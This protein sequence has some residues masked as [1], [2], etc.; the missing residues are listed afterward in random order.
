MGLHIVSGDWHGSLG[1][2]RKVI[3]AAH[4][5]GVNHIIQTG[6]FGWWPHYE[7]SYPGQVNDFAQ[8]RGVTVDWLD[9]NHENFDDLDQRDHDLDPQG[10]RHYER[11][12]S[13]TGRRL[14][15]LGYMP[16][17]TVFDLDGRR[18]MAFGGASSIDK[19]SRR[20]HLEWW[21]Q[22]NI[23]QG[24]VYNA[25][26]AGP[27]DYL[28]THEAPQL[29]PGLPGDWKND[30]ISNT[31]RHAIAL[32]AS[33]LAP[34]VLFHGHYH[35]PYNRQY[36]RQTMVYGLGADRNLNGTRGEGNAVLLDTDKNSVHPFDL[37]IPQPIDE[38]GEWFHDERGRGHV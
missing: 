29:P 26:D 10:F 8:K 13:A 23:T 36:N 11:P 20:P 25:L 31:N 22:E 9:G 6:D 37:S 1:H 34:R 21:P 3:E 4:K 17:G 28:F 12:G 5:A 14:T 30:P 32:L 24:Q 2:A 7:P 38:F 18:A 35:L 27:V 15:H 33:E 19:S 16:R